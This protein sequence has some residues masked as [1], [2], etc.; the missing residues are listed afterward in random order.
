M[1]K[2]NLINI[3]II[4]S[5]LFLLVS[6]PLSKLPVDTLTILGTGTDTS[7]GLTGSATATALSTEPATSPTVDNKKQYTKTKT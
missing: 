7:T 3:N 5:H 6:L 2:F 1:H 4:F